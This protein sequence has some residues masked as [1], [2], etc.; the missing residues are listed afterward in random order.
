M[1]QARTGRCLVFDLDD[2]LYDEIDFVASGYDAVAQEVLTRFGV[3]CRDILRQ[4]LDAGQLDG[5]FQAAIRAGLPADALSLMVTTYRD[6]Y[7]SIRPRPGVARMLTSV[8]DRDGVA[9][10]ITDGRGRTQRN[11][12]A[13]LG[14]ASILD[15]ILVSEETGHAKPDPHNFREMM[16]RVSAEEYWYVADNPAKDFVAPN[17]LGWITVG[18][19]APRGIHRSH[20]EP[21]AGHRPRLQATLEAALDLIEQPVPRHQT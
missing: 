3:D 11:K 14:F 5:A 12:I 6:H 17:G 2:T 9:G 18:I 20:G 16:R 1:S 8:K 10:C 13:A 19:D 21:A 15:P 4:H 7:P